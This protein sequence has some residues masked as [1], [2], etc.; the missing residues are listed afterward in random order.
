MLRIY[1]DENVERA[2]ADGLKRRNIDVWTVNDCNN[3]GLSDEQQLQFAVEKKAALFNYDT[4]FFE[5][6]KHWSD[7]VKTHYGIFYTHPISAN[8]GECIRKLKEYAEL[9]NPDDIINQIIFL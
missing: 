2:I 3:V 4:D 8:I 7:A 6:S 5:I 9:F 1:I